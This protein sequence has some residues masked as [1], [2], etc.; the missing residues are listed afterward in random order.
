MIRNLQYGDEGTVLRQRNSNAKALRQEPVR[1][2]GGTQEKT[3]GSV[4]NEKDAGS[5]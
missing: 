5:R 2:L 3:A 1:C 4:V